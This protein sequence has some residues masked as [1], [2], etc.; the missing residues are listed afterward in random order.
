MKIPS[1]IITL[2]VGVLITLISLWYGQNHGLMPVAASED[3]KQVDNIFSFMMTIATFLF[4]LVEGV[5]IYSVIRFRRRQGD[6]TDGP[7]I[8]GNVPLEILWTAIPTII[9]FILAIYSFEAYNNMG[10]LDPMTSGNAGPQQIAMEGHNHQL[11]LGIGRSFDENGDN[12][13]LVVEVKA[14]QYA[15]IFTY[16]DTGIVSGELHVP[17]DRPVRLNLN[18]GDVLH[19]FWVPQLRLKQ[20]AIPGRE[21]IIGFTA[22]LEGNYPIICAELCG[23][24]HGGMKSVLYVENAETYAQWEESNKPVQEAR[25]DETIPV[26]PQ[27]LSDG[28]FLSPYA[29]EM[30]IKSETVAQLVGH[31]HHF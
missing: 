16:P 2:I 28:E 6:Q 26:N 10:G 13:P 1:N 31:H 29:Q 27:T 30:G 24:Y 25:L 23:A 11:A 18:A 4:L 5:L 17:K 3:A 19:A 14:I 22:N 20:D 9:V 21:A 15:W 7:P 12:P 8:E